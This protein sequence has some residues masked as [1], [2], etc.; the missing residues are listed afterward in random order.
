M[1]K[2]RHSRSGLF[3]MEIIIN[4]L[5]FSILITFCLQIFAKAHRLSDD[6]QK[7]HQAV[8]ICSSIAQICQSAGSDSTGSEDAG[9]LLLSQYPDAVNNSTCIEIFFDDSFQP[10]GY[11]DSSYKAAVVLQDNMTDLSNIAFTKTSS[12]DNIYTLSF[13]TYIPDYWNGGAAHE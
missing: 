2:Y 9:K 13:C 6:T 1:N 4:I 8:T 10:C 7:L 5:F 11:S 12:A 3:L